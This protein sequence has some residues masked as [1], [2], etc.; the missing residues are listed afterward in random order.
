MAAG[1]AFARFHGAAFNSY[2]RSGST[3]ENASLFPLVPVEV[4]LLDDDGEIKRCSVRWYQINEMLGT[5]LRALMQRIQGRDLFD[6]YHARDLGATDVSP[7]PYVVDQ[8]QAIE[9][10]NY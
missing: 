6:L 5:K 3:N 10:F 7:Y 2:V 9:A 4:D 8:A 1:P